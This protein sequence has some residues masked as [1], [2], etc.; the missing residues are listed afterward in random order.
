ML[1]ELLNR[2]WLLDSPAV[3][4]DTR[5]CDGTPIRIVR[6]DLL[7]PWASGNKLRK[8]DAWL[9]EM[10]RQGV[11]VVITCGG[12]QSAHA[13]SV[14]ALSADVGMRAHLFLRGEPLEHPTGYNLLSHFF[15]EVSYVDRD[16]YADRGFLEAEATRL[17]EKGQEVAV[18]PEGAGGVLA[19][20]GIIR[21]V[22]G[23]MLATEDP[24]STKLELV[25]DAGTGTTAAGL[26]LGVALLELPWT[27]S[28]ICL[29]PESLESYQSHARRLFDRWSEHEQAPKR[30]PEVVWNE[31][32]QPRRFGQ[33]LDGEFEKCRLIA[34]STGLLFDPIYTLA[35]WDAIEHRK[36]RHRKGCVLVHTGGGLNLF[37][38]A[39]RYNISFR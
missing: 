11:E 8:L 14:G 28:A 39:S 26:A 17:R 1:D 36:A 13:A 37:G 10:R 7:H 33:V 30:A 5:E 31:R 29:V 3:R 18:I 16:R 4:L 32:S 20:Y 24:F 22:H 25:V 23:M 21:L 9:P 34:R 35:A 6:D 27:V 15:G 38:I 19:L 12:V 2:R